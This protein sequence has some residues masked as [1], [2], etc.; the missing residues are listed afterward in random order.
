MNDPNNKSNASTQQEPS[1]TLAQQEKSPEQ[2]LDKLLA[3]LKC[4]KDGS[5]HKE[6]NE[7]NHEV[8]KKFANI[9]ECLLKSN[10]DYYPF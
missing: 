3:L 10:I 1:S 6:K 4:M 9:M 7:M 5:V 2:K 8:F